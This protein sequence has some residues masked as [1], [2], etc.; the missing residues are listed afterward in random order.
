MGGRS[1]LEE[2]I[3]GVKG[4]AAQKRLRTAVMECKV[5]KIDN[6]SLYFEVLHTQDFSCYKSDSLI[7]LNFVLEPYRYCIPNPPIHIDVPQLAT[8]VPITMKKQSSLASRAIQITLAR[9]E[10]ILNTHRGV[11]VDFQF[12]RIQNNADFVKGEHRDLFGL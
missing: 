12:I 6:L 5:V 8:L 4:V 3:R 2:G 9:C 10:Y 1:P 11:S 7:N